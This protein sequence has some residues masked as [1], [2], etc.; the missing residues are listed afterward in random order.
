MRC[1]YQH[2]P[3]KLPYR[4]IQEYQPKNE[5][6][7]ETGEYS[8]HNNNEPSVELTPEYVTDDNN[9]DNDGDSDHVSDGEIVDVESVRNVGDMDVTDSA[10][11]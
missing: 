4:Q 11:F 6:T 3:G 9:S 1:V 2:S 7:L 10:V 8:G 5:L